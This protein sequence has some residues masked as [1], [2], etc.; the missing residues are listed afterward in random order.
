MRRSQPITLL[1]CTITCGDEAATTPVRAS[2]GICERGIWE[3]K[4]AQH[5]SFRAQVC[6]SL[7]PHAW[8][9][10]GTAR[11]RQAAAAAV[12]LHRLV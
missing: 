7:L 8:A 6:E 12:A 1:S 4:Q 2:H 9:A 11:C 10:Q 3:A 5:T